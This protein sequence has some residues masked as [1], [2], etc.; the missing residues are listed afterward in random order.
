MASSCWSRWWRPSR[1][2]SSACRSC[3][4]WP[5]GLQSAATSMRASARCSPHRRPLN[6]MSPRCSQTLRSLRRVTIF[7]A[8]T[9]LRGTP[10]KMRAVSRACC[11]RSPTIRPRYRSSTQATVT[12][13]AMSSNACALP[14]A[15]PRS[16]TASCLHRVLRQLPE[17]RRRASRRVRRTIESRSESTARRPPPRS[18]RASCPITHANPRLS[19][20][21][22][23][24]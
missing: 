12:W 20:R 8:T 9:S 21:V 15:T 22:L 24:E 3:A 16:R 1:W 23:D 13:R 5:P 19:W 2:P 4:R 11:A 10:A 14:Q 18:C 17:H 6:A 7:R